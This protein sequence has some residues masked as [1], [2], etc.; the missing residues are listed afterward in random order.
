VVVWN[1]EGS[2]IIGVD[3]ANLTSA[4]AEWDKARALAETVGMNANIVPPG[5]SWRDVYEAASKLKNEAEIFAKSTKARKTS[6]VTVDGDLSEWKDTE[7]LYC[8]V[9]VKQ[10]YSV[11]VEYKDAHFFCGWDDNGVYLAGNV[12]DEAT[13][14]RYKDK[15]IW[16]GDCI[17]LFIDLRPDDDP[18]NTTY[19]TGTYQFLFSPTNV[20]GKPDMAVIN[21]SLTSSYRP[22]KVKLSVKSTGD[23]WIFEC[24]IPSTELGNWKPKVGETIG[25]TIGLDDSDGGDRSLQYMWRGKGDASRNRSRFGRLT[26]TE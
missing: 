25:F 17:E 11:P 23:G 16:N 2:E 13:V 9:Q 14:N 15:M 24:Y 8:A 10:D 7:P 5:E 3:E 21:T 4:V 26:F 19:N 20:E 22:E 6:A 18:M 12:K 1:I